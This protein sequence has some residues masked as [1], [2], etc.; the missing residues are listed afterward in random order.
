M[1]RYPFTRPSE[2]W[3][4]FVGDAGAW[5]PAGFDAEMRLRLA[6]YLDDQVGDLRETLERKFPETH[7][8][9]TPVTLPLVRLLTNE[10]AKVFL[11]T[12]KLEVVEPGK[13]EAD[14]SLVAWW[15]AVQ[16]QAGLAL[17]LKRV[18]A[19]TT[20]LRTAGLQIAYA[21]GGLRATVVFPQQLQVV[22]DPAA[23]MDLDQA[24]GVALEVASEAGLRDTGKRRYEFWCAREGEEQHLLLELD[25]ENAMVVSRDDGDPLRGPGERSLVPIVL[26]TAHTEELGLFT[27]EGR[28]L[29]EA[30]RDLNVLVTDIHHIAEQQGFGVM[31]ITSPQGEDAPPKIVRA[32]NTAISLKGGVDA[33]FID[34]AAPLADL[35][36]LADT[37]IKQA[38]VLR[39]LPAGTV[40]VEARAVAS[41]VALQIE[42]RSLLEARA[43]A[44]EVYR[45]PMRRLWDVIR[46]THNAYR[47]Q[48][49]FLAQVWA[50]ISGAAK[51]RIGEIAED[52]DLRW[53][54]GDVQLPVDD[55]RRVDT[56][57]TKLKSRLCTRA[58]AIAELRG[59]SI[60]EAK[61]V[62]KQIDAEEPAAGTV[63]PLMGLEPV[64]EAL[65]A[66]NAEEAPAAPGAEAIKDTSLNGAQIASLLEIIKSAV[67]RDL[68]V[69][70]AQL[71][72]EA[73][74]PGIAPALLARIIAGVRRAPKP[75]D[76]AP[77]P[78][79][80][81]G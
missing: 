43:D 15:K 37:R 30:N 62:L 35:A 6:Y 17:R 52:V 65:G 31:V 28:G 49:G 68:P 80:P 36:A 66:A 57:V 7:K 19:Y 76:P 33:K 71:L 12:T 45:E 5:K 59:I 40:S 74:F 47:G 21:D 73:A 69:D 64:R 72:V 10:T 56:V 20:L 1:T 60:E 34:P 50:R 42:M 81:Q 27:V 14:E 79:P 16:E 39:G 63:D 32:P 3:K 55:D 13:D 77:A 54:P 38:A 67:D 51:G 41:G 11:S 61:K 75:A 23:P 26:F 48:P 70:V 9:L 44:I 46:A 22:M 53:T 25:G 29:V 24:H 4:R 18:D 2:D 78:A 8:Q 58:E